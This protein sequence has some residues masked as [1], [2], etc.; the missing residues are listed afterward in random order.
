MFPYNIH[1]NDF[2][3]NLRKAL[4]RIFGVKVELRVDLVVCLKF[5][6][7]VPFFSVLLRNQDVLAY[8][9]LK[10]SQE[11]NIGNGVASTNVRLSYLDSTLQS[12]ACVAQCHLSRP[13]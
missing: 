13:P 2:Q 9:S 10:F 1:T 7:T 3:I 4:A 11:M 8:S 6:A 12:T 5:N